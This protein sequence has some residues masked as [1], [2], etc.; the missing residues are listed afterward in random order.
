MVEKIVEI[1]GGG[2]GEVGGSDPRDALAVDV[3]GHHVDVRGVGQEPTSKFRI[4]RRQ[5]LL[6]AEHDFRCCRVIG[7]G[8]R[9]DQPLER[10]QLV[11]GVQIALVETRPKPANGFVVPAENRV[12]H[13]CRD[14]PPRG[15]RTGRQ[16]I[17]T[18]HDSR[19]LSAEL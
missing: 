1:D 15:H 14:V 6:G 13:A 18:Q 3:A 17:P 9:P 10:E 12:R 5:K 2:E 7:Q 19:R 8:E 11:R 16:A 4:R